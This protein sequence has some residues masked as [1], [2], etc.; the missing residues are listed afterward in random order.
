MDDSINYKKAEQLCAKASKWLHP[1]MWN[2]LFKSVEE[3][4]DKAFNYFEEASDLYLIDKHYTKAGDCL[5][6]CAKIK[7][8]Q[9]ESFIHYLENA[10]S[11]YMKDSN[12]SSK[13]IYIIS[14]TNNNLLDRNE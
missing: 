5:V 14:L 13:P 1:N 7:E 3:R 9:K 8:E 6:K 10:K 11:C 4:G 12:S 2:A